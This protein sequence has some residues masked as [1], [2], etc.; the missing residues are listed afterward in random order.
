MKYLCIA[1]IAFLLVI[2]AVNAE[3]FS[4]T[5]KGTEKDGWVFL[6]SFAFD[7][8]PVPL[9]KPDA[10]QVVGWIDVELT[11]KDKNDWGHDFTLWQHT[12]NGPD[13]PRIYQD[14]WSCEEK[15]QMS[16]GN[17]QKV[18]T[19]DANTGKAVVQ[20]EALGGVRR[21]FHYASLVHCGGFGKFDYKLHFTRKASAWSREFGVNVAGLNTVYILFFCLYFF[22]AGG[23]A[24]N[25]KNFKDTKPFVHPIVKVFTVSVIA[26]FVNIFLEMI[27]W[28]RFKDTG[29]RMPFIKFIADLGELVGAVSFLLLLMLLAQGWAVSSGASNTNLKR[30]T[31][32]ASVVLLYGVLKF[33][34]VCLN[35]FANDAA[36]V[37]TANK[38]YVFYNILLVATLGFAAF[39]AVSLFQTTRMENNPVKRKFMLLLQV[40]SFYLLLTSLSAIISY[41]VDPW[42][43]D[44]I[45]DLVALLSISVAHIGMLYL[46]WN[47]RASKYFELESPVE[48]S[49]QYTSSEPAFDQF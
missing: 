45:V 42:V 13:W 47:S 12:D 44:M 19:V 43:R 11:F 20:L 2:S 41:A 33:I 25:Y 15:Q 31:V 29:V 37:G 46:L 18:F 24:Y 17:P 3:R 35:S 36:L 26:S 16:M 23:A 39:Y 27:H 14:K 38:V 5:K 49:S 21:R 40:F 10:R 22:V 1:L 48:L 30:R 8:N 34:S 4:G 6:G 7:E 32:V 28:C 9:N